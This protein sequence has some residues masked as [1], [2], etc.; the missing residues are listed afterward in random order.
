MC[1]GTTVLM[2]KNSEHFSQTQATLTAKLIC[3][4]KN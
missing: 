2:I 3:S 1:K 4:I